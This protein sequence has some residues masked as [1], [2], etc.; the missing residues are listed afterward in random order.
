MTSFTS[1]RKA[2]GPPRRR[3][4]GRARSAPYLFVAPFVALFL[5]F[6]VAP[7]LYAI[8]SSFF[9]MRRSG[10]GLD[11]EGPSLEFVGFDNFRAALGDSEFLAG[12]GRVFLFGIVQV[13]VMLGLALVFAL[14]IDSALVRFKK[15]VQL[16]I[17][18]PY[19]IPG[20]VAAL[21][22]GFLYQPGVS[23]VVGF[24][25]SVGVQADFL[26]PGTVLWSIANVTTWSYIGVNM[27]IL[28][29]ALQAIPT[30]VYEAARL[31]GAGGLRIALGIKLPLILPTLLLTCLMSIIGTL[32]LFN[33]PEVLRSLTS[34]V[35]SD[36]TPNMAI[37]EVTTM[38]N[39]RNLGAAMAIVL[40]VVSLVL[41]LA[42]S[43]FDRSK[44]SP[45]R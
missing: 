37:L 38:G 22:W 10:L 16:V 35:S 20:V 45:K 2:A 1:A 12:F 3:N 11:G 9:G 40:A 27:V 14:L 28:F 42:V 21:L 19:A 26:A 15:S 5:A 34:N 31:D 6:L 29:A 41:S 43:R 24:L 39:N 25:E 8:V 33:E 17:F 32:Q 44:E 7:T 36:F 23:P 18:L 4:R 13:P 30:D